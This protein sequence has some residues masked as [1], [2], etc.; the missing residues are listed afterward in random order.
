MKKALD[1][2]RPCYSDIEGLNMPGVL[3]APDD[4]RTTPEG[5]FIVYDEAQKRP[6]SPVRVGP[7]CLSIPATAGAQ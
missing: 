1:A 7:A 2:G 3:P 5:S 4:W 6:S